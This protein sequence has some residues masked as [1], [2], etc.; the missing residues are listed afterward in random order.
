MEPRTQRVILNVV[1]LVFVS[2]AL[3]LQWLQGTV[4]VYAWGSL[5]IA[6][7]AMLAARYLRAQMD[8]TK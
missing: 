3:F 6:L 2:I 1:G 7:V 8:K 4:S 5:V